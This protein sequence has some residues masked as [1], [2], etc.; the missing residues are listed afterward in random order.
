MGEES[1]GSV[2]VVEAGEKV[3]HDGA[4]GKAVA[5]DWV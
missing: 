3:A 2:L 5:G 4:T 1:E